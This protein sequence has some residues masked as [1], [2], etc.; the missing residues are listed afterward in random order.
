MRLKPQ[1]FLGCLR[2]LP[3]FLAAGKM[4]SNLNIQNFFVEC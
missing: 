3:Y 4:G 2:T 1:K